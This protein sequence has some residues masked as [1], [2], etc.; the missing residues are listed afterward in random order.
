MSVISGIAPTKSKSLSIAPGQKI[1]SISNKT[2]RS[3]K[4]AKVTT[5]RSQGNA[6]LEGVT[7][8]ADEP[9]NALIVMAEPQQY[10]VLSKIIK[11]LDV[12]PLQ[13]LIDATIVAVKLDDDLS[14]GVQWKFSHS[15]PN[16]S[17]GGGLG[18]PT[19]GG[20]LASAVSGGFTYG[21]LRSEGDVRLMFTALAKDERINVLS[22]PSLMV[23]NNQEAT[24]KV[25]DS[26][27]IRTAE[28]TNTSGSLDPIQT[29]SIEMLDTG[30]I[31]KVKPRVN[32]SG[33][34]ILEI[35]QSVDTA[36]KTTSD[37][38]TSNIDSPTILKRQ[39]QTTVTVV[40]GESIV[41]GGLI[42]EQHTFDNTG[43]P[44]LKDI[45]YIGWL[46]GVQGKK[47]IKDELIVI[48]TPRVVANKFDARK[49]TD[50]FK[51]KLSG[52]YYDEDIFTPGADQV[53]RGYDGLE[54][55]TEEQREAPMVDEEVI[56]PSRRSPAQ[57]EYDGI[58]Y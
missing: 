33:M 49:V 30:V 51:R 38:G 40:D 56:F 5:S 37:T 44:F 28:S 53:R 41:L 55:Q 23:L 45:P 20:L 8:I 17:G 50:E 15:G 36:S 47:V 2:T 4:V 42:N 48:I 24:I 11:H 26:V 16:G 57:R 12:M 21:L 19:T 7:I 22:S 3:P 25:G 43:I 1:A 35:D 58:T 32:A 46:F 10:R 6:S 54:V 52:I 27:P 34:I 9:N 29:S 13:V 39:I 31:L 18:N 14:Y